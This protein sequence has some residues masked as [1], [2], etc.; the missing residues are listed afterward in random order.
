MLTV[1]GG[2]GVVMGYVTPMTVTEQPG[3]LTYAFWGFGM[4]GLLVG[5]VFTFP[6][7]WMLVKVGWKHGMGG[8]EGADEAEGKKPRAALFATMGVLGLAALVLPAW[9]FEIREGTPV[10]TDSERFAPF[11]QVVVRGDRSVF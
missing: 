2:M 8:M 10:E 7:N 5:Y 6:M 11:R 1:M 4:L 9:L 3:P